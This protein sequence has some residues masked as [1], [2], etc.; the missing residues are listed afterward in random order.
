MNPQEQA[1][2]IYP[3]LDDMGMQPL[4]P[5]RPHPHY[6]NRWVQPWSDGTVRNSQEPGRLTV[7][8][9]HFVR[10]G[11]NGQYGLVQVGPFEGW[12]IAAKET[13][14]QGVAK[15]PRKIAA[16]AIGIV[17]VLGTGRGKVA[18]AAT[19]LLLIAT[20]LP[21]DEAV[22]PLAVAATVAVGGT[23][24]VASTRKRLNAKPRNTHTH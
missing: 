6:Q 18:A 7:I 12:G 1:W 10:E 22:G 11:D 8:N 3:I 24:A 13:V 15:D 2:R 19:E 20:P 14:R 9:D 5:S 17:K 4:G 21:L 23:M 16:L